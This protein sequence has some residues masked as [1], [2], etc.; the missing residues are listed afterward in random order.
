MDDRALRIQI[1]R[2][3][4]LTD[5][6][7]WGAYSRSWHRGWPG[8]WRGEQGRVVFPKRKDD[9]PDGLR[10]SEQEA[11][12]SFVETI[13]QSPFLYSAETPTQ[14]RAYKKAGNID[15][16][17]YTHDNRRVCNIE[18]K[19]RGAYPLYA[20]LIKLLCEKT[21]GLGFHLFAEDQIDLDGITHELCASIL[22][23]R[24]EYAE[25]LLSQNLIIHL[26]FLYQGFSL[27]KEIPF[28]AKDSDLQDA[29]SVQVGLTEDKSELS[30]PLELSG[31][32]GWMFHR[33]E[34]LEAPE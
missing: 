10:I 15:L 4:R 20:D 8:D 9:K 18:F 21:W 13:H 5:C 14:T 25:H 11:R 30:C 26:C 33:R 32:N 29:L 3:C 31:L 6:F 23:V 2:S 34:S 17:L 1:S 12:F 24:E 7:L 19:C 22:R 28:R 27:E 16:S